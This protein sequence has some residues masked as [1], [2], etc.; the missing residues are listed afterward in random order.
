MRSRNWKRITVLVVETREYFGRTCRDK[1]SGNSKS[2]LA[3][4]LDD[5]RTRETEMKSQIS[6]LYSQLETMASDAKRLQEEEEQ[7]LRMSLLKCWR[8]LMVRCFL[9]LFFP[10]T[11][12]HTHSITDTNEEVRDL[13]SSLQGLHEVVKFLRR[14][15]YCRVSC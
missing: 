10:L 2:S 9:S 11:H 8:R 15:R 4:Q 7:N 3:T 14:E 5:M 13:R 6:L 1:V 12:T